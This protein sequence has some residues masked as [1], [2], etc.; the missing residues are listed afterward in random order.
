MDATA[1]LADP[2]GDAAGRAAKA[3]SGAASAGDVAIALDKVSKRFADGTVAVQEISLAVPRG[4]LVC[5]VG[6]SGCGKTTTLKMVNRLI[7]PTGGRIILEGEDVTKADP[8][9]LRRRIGYVI[10]QVGLFP[11][12]TVAA[13]VAT[14]PRLLG[15]S[16]KRQRERANEL[17]ELVGLEPSQYGPR[18][19]SQLSGGQRQRVGVARALGADPEVLLMDEPF[20]A[21]DPIAR[22]RL[23]DEFLRVQAA[24]RKTILF[25]THD[26]DE[27]VRLGD[28][29]AVFRQGGLLE[30]YD[31]PARMLGAPA[32]DFV[33]DFVGMDRGLRRLAVTTVDAADLEAPPVVPPSASTS[34]ARSLLAGA[35][36]GIV[37]GDDGRLLGRV[38]PAMLDGS[39]GAADIAADLAQPPA[40][41]V[42]VGTTLKDAL[43]LMLQHD[44]GW[45]AVTDGGRYVGVLAPGSL[46]SALRRSVETDATDAAA[47]PTSPPPGQ[48]GATG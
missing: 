9:E 15:W 24:V 37:V 46:H 34:E 40:G 31:P 22:A 48:P 4:E 44:D 27:A 10:Q 14:V 21:I 23:Q 41:V 26:I 25:V 28:R 3:G 35:P 1:A 17:L 18:Y 45:V 6:P 38:S 2:P 11:H 36:Y 33:A 8:V 12:L 5:L 39:S 20:S 32:T 29:V 16:K 7:E 43:S 42:D 30:Q 19:P 13:N 47:G